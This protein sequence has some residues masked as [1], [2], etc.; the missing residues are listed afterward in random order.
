MKH[1]GKVWSGRRWKKA[2]VAH[3]PGPKVIRS[4]PVWP[5]S[6]RVRQKVNACWRKIP[7]GAINQCIADR[8]TTPSARSGLE[9][10][11]WPSVPLVLA[12]CGA[13]PMNC[14][15]IPADYAVTG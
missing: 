2:E 8:R 12:V 6:P 5:A 4:M 10:W 9:A 3:R 15:D 11:A 14:V 13:I 1:F 7:V